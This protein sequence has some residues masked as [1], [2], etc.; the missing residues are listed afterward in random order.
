MQLELLNFEF[1]AG[2]SGSGEIFPEIEREGYVE[3]M[4]ML[5]MGKAP[6]EMRSFYDEPATGFQNA[7]ELPHDIERFI[8]V[9]E[10]MKCFDE[11]EWIF[12]EGI[13]E[14]IQVM[15]YI[16]IVVF[17]P[18]HIYVSLFFEYAAS[19]IKFFCCVLVVHFNIAITTSAD[20][21]IVLQ[22][23]GNA[24]GSLNLWW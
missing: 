7:V 14:R 6:A 3:S 12:F 11:F 22:N 18:I 9:L 13:G 17:V 2:K 16:W 15:N 20:I 8:E 4:A 23:S 24:M 5:R 21:Y 1:H 10:H 19:K